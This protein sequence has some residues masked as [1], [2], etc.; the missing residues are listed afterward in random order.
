MFNL[1]SS[2][3]WQKSRPHLFLLSGFLNPQEEY[4][5]GR[6]HGHDSNEWAEVLGEPLQKAIQRFMKEG[7]IVKTN[8]LVDY[9][10]YKFK[11]S[12]LKTMLKKRGLAVSGRKDELISRLIENDTNGVKKAVS[13][14]SLVRCSDGGQ[15]IA[16][17]F[18]FQEKQHKENIEEQMVLAFRSHRFRDAI[19][20]YYRFQASQVFPTSPSLSKP[21]PLAVRKWW[22]N[23]D[24][25]EEISVINLMFAKTPKSLSKLNDKELEDVRIAASMYELWEIQKYLEFPSSQQSETSYSPKDAA[26]AV[27]R[28]AYHCR[29]LL[30]YQKRGIKTIGIDSFNDACDACKEMAKKR[31]ALNEVPELPYEHCTSPNGCRCGLSVE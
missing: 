16:E 22:E 4:H 25:T 27:W 6:F 2:F 9:V 15:K 5:Q 20:T 19:Q 28:Y 10:E 12:E 21:N 1:F 7:L 17:Q 11:L 8:S 31:Y 14:L 13:G 26:F 30:D 3:D 24:P 29:N 18:V 23:R